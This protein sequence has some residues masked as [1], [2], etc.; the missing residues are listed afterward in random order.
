MTQNRIFLIVALCMTGV[1]MLISGCKPDPEPD[2]IPED[3]DPRITIMDPTSG[4][5]LDTIGAPIS[6]Q[7]RLDD[8]EFLTEFRVAE[9]WIDPYGNEVLPE[10]QIYSQNLSEGHWVTTYS[11]YTV[12]QVQLYSKIELI[13]Y[14]IDS[15]GKV[16]KAVFTINV[17]PT[18]S[19]APEFLVEEYPDGDTIW[20]G[21]NTAGKF[22]FDFVNRTN[23]VTNS[24]R[25]DI[26]ESSTTGFQRTLTSPNNGATDSV[27]VVTNSS[28]FNYDQ[29]TYQSAWEAFVTNPNQL[30]ETGQ[31]NVGDI[32]LIKSPPTTP[33]L[34]AMRIKAISPNTFPYMVFE[35]K[36][37][38]E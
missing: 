19:D 15:K 28:L 8:N 2:P 37:T 31:L 32:V 3:G 36:R 30:T 17:I 14:A 10:T 22:Y 24:A 7:Y 33:H 6:L 27:M 13:A 18:P 23:V 25:R 34:V 21:T 26:G 16:D 12:P 38:Y 1:A 4:Y 5:S 20:T 35:Y 29:M 11:N 9:R